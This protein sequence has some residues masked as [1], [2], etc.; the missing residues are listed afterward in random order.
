MD[1][2]NLKVSL[3]FV[4]PTKN[5]FRLD[6]ALELIVGIYP[7]VVAR[8]SEFSDFNR[9]SKSTDQMKLLNLIRMWS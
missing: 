9:I 8:E 4:Y 2:D 6:T 5:M 7:K 1:S 3:S